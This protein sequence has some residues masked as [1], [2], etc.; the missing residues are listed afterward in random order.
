[1]NKKE[2]LTLTGTF[3]RT[4]TVVDE[5]IFSALEKFHREILSGTYNSTEAYRLAVKIKK[6]IDNCRIGV[7]FIVDRTVKY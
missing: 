5:K 1:M 3:P 7:E 4:I 6:E 2:T